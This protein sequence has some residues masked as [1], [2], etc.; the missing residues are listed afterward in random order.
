MLQ[1]DGTHP[2]DAG[3][4]KMAENWKAAFDLHAPYTPK[5]IWLGSVSSDWHHAGNWKNAS[6][7][8]SSNS[9]YIPSTA[10]NWPVFIG[11]FAV[12]TDCFNLVMEGSSELT[13]SG[14]LTISAGKVLSVR[15]GATIKVSGDYT[16]SG[17]LLAGNGS[18]EFNGASS[19]NLNPNTTYFGGG[20]IDKSEGTNYN[21]STYNRFDCFQDFTLI[22]AK[23]YALSA[24]TETFYWATESGAIQEQVTV[25]FP[26]GESRV[27]LDFHITPG[28]NHRLGKSGNEN[29][30]RDKDPSNLGLDFPY[31]IG[32]LAIITSTTFGTR[33]YYFFYDIEYS[34]SF[35]N[36][37]IAKT[38]GE[39]STT[40]D[41]VLAG[42]LSINPDAYFTIG[43][44]NDLEIGGDFNHKADATGM[45]SF[46]NEGTFSVGGTSRVEQYVTSD[47][48]HY[49]SSP[50]S[51]GLSGVYTGVYLKSFN[52]PT[53][54]WNAYISTTT[55]PLG[56]MTGY[57]AWNFTD[58]FTATFEG[59]LNDG[60]QSIAVTAQYAGPDDI[61]YNLVGNPFS[62]AL[63]WDLPGWTKTNVDNTIYFYEGNGSGGVG[64]YRY[65]Q[66]TGGE[67]PGIGT[68]TLSSIIPSM[69]G[70]FIRAS[71]DGSLAVTNDARTHD[72]QDFYKQGKSYTDPLIRLMAVDANNLEDEAIIRFFD[73]AT[74]EHDGAYDAFKLFGYLYP[75]LYS[76]T[77]QN[78]QLAI[79]TLPGYENGTIIPL[80]FISPE[81]GAYAITL[82]EFENFDPGTELFLEDKL[83][84]ETQLLNDNPTY[85]FVSQPD[86]DPNRF[87]LY[88][89]VLTDVEK[90]VESS[91]Y[92]YAY[93]NNVMIKLPEITETAQVTIYN[94]MGQ[95][96]AEQKIDGSTNTLSIDAIPGNYIV[97]IQSDELLYTQK[98][99]IK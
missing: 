7:P 86:D 54:S 14:N 16:N 57:A 98:V 51:N 59:T 85:Q 46:I 20:K 28:I 79:N 45:S 36:M 35:N 29:L 21:G 18:I 43:T 1:I 25:A 48:W 56:I 23:I 37:L 49:V 67:L 30:W 68:Q 89:N 44:A 11:N 95:K 4:L 33:Y 90:L 6:I 66:G 41:I 76:L 52:E 24:G 64:N 32:N 50:I 78:S 96:I 19:S 84:G 15:E 83:T 73:E 2:N 93:D 12:G 22:S 31:M 34:S 3:D 40:G 72:N 75:Q 62:S 82:S 70:F 17:E 60:N 94:M 27:T 55:E 65:Y 8:G 61:G 77:E 53:N 97:V 71:A 39:V 47:K 9:V 74:P 38:D 13:I 87:M 80:G 81:A 10:T 58:P 26:A 99:Y 42:D 5:Y 91:V 92:V 88:F 69:Q 63:D